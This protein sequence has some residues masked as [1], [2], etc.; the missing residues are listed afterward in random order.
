MITSAPAWASFN[1]HARP[2]PREL[3]LTRAT[4]FV[5]S[6][7]GTTANE[8]ERV[9]FVLCLIVRARDGAQTDRRF[10]CQNRNYR[11]M[12]VDVLY[13]ERQRRDDLPSITASQTARGAG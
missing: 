6:I 10:V 13:V 4:L 12:P 8:S 7:M 3:P 2:M 5:R 11:R 9:E 1:A